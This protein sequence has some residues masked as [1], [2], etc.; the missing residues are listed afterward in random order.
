MTL[1][2]IVD[3]EMVVSGIAPATVDQ[4]II[5]DAVRVGNG[6]IVAI[7]NKSDWDP[8]EA[9]YQAIQDIGNL[10]AIWWIIRGWDDKMYG[11][12]KKQT[13]QAY[14]DSITDFKDST[15]KDIDANPDFDIVTTPEV[16]PSLDNNVE[17]YLSDWYH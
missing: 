6:K 11:E 4:T 1:P 3:P 2:S 16:I 8:N 17:P 13:Y 10:Y 7:T 5:D 9:I 12:L 15:F 14:R